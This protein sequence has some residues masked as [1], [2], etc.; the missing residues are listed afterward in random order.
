LG[1]ILPECDRIAVSDL[2]ELRQVRVVRNYGGSLVL[3]R[4]RGH[5]GKGS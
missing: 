1:Q 4:F 3:L 2:Q 5:L